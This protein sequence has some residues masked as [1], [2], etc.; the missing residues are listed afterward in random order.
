MPW[1]KFQMERGLLIGGDR[2]IEVEGYVAK[3]DKP[4]TPATALVIEAHGGLKFKP[5]MSSKKKKRKR[6][7]KK[8]KR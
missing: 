6:K 8:K 4:I 7:V 5:P 2:D 3:V 1:F